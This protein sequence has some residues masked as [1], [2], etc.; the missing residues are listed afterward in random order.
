MVTLLLVDDEDLVRRGIKAFVDFEKLRIDQ[1][2]EASN[3]L[4]ALV[5]FENNDIQ[6]VLMD[7]NMPKMNGIEVAKEMKALKPQVK[8]AMLTGYDYFD[9]A[10]SALKAGVDDYIL[11]PVSKGDVSDV[12]SRLIQSLQKDLMKSAANTVVEGLL[13]ASG[14]ERERTYQVE[15]RDKV[16]AQLAKPTFSL[17]VLADQM[18][19]SAGYLST[20]FKE[21]FGLPFQEYVLSQRLEK[22]KLLLLSTNMKNYEVAEMVG[23]EDVNYFGTRF[24]KK[25][26][27]SPKQYQQKVRHADA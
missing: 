11:K 10:V 2:L 12:L 27:V 4:Q 8:I 6:L 25:Y 3:G 22:A 5:M 16:D 26:G 17:S 1:V 21:L 14:S 7:I 18:G 23:F 9:Y 20:L 24:K 19:F 15:L 13:K